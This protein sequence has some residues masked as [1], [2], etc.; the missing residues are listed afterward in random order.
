MLKP[1]H[2]EI[3][4]I[5]LDG[6][7]SSRAL[8]KMIAANLKQDHLSGL[9]GHDEYH[10]DNNAF[11][12]SNAYI[13]EQRALVLSSLRANHVASA[14]SAFGRLTHAVHDFY[15]HTNYIELWLACHS[16]GAAPA[17]PDVDPLDSDVIYSPALRSGKVYILEALTLIPGFKPL[18][19]PLL[20]HDS[21]AWMNIDSPGHGTNFSYA[22]QAAIKR[23]KIEFERIV[24]E[25]PGNLIQLFMDR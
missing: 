15:A 24:G 10:F 5:A 1:Y 13:E 17:P 4:R 21:H 9:L 2:I 19:M 22:F 23:T 7:V 3:M 18:V 12:E 8:E 16:A 20:P 6:I 11:A 14:W 25:L